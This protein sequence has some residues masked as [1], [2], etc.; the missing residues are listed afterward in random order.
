MEKRVKKSIAGFKWYAKERNPAKTSV[1]SQ[2]V[3]NDKTKSK[4]D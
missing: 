1:D 2:I 4:K 3:D